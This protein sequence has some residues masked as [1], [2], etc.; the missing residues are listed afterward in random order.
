MFRP[1]TEDLLPRMAPKPSAPIGL[2]EAVVRPQ[3]PEVSILFGK[4]SDEN[5]E[6]NSNTGI[7]QQQSYAVW[8]KQMLPRVT[9]P[10]SFE[11]KERRHLRSDILGNNVN[12]ENVYCR[13]N[14]YPLK[15]APTTPFLSSP[16]INANG[17]YRQNLDNNT[18]PF[19]QQHQYPGKP[20]EVA[21][22]LVSAMNR[23]VLTICA[24]TQTDATVSPSKLDGFP[25]VPWHS[26]AAKQD[27]QD[28]LQMVQDIRQDQLC[29]MQICQA[30]IINQQ[31][32]QE[33]PQMQNVATQVEDEIYEHICRD[34]Q[35]QHAMGP[36]NKFLKNVIS[37]PSSYHT[38][39][40]K[41]TAQS[42]T[43][44][45]NSPQADYMPAPFEGNQKAGFSKTGSDRSLLM[46]QLALK[47]LPREKLAELL[48]E[49]NVD[50]PATEQKELL[51]EPPASNNIPLRNIEN[52]E[53]GPADISNASYKYLKKYRLLPEDHSQPEN[54]PITNDVADCGQLYDMGQSP[55][56]NLRQPPLMHRK[57]TPYQQAGQ[58]GD[59]PPLAVASPEQLDLENIKHQPKFL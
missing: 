49:L 43:Y 16:S 55:P 30:L 59:G 34:V 47:Y 19:Y 42:T 58:D 26:L 54:I 10:S 27:V 25:N 14:V 37:S 6:K 48:Q 2:N 5:N 15:E 21:A 4:K 7:Q 53:R 52:Y 18:N 22:P 12:A 3:V 17:A 51:T 39:K 57:I 29:I 44:K 9:F 41:P 8:K 28:L 1:E 46:G 24:S 11:Q 32:Q 40:G 31:N 23:D 56:I 38:P 35:E 13:S 36:V 45:P 20:L 50:C 33:R